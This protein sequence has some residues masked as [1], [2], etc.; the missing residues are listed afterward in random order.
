MRKTLP[1]SSI[2][3]LLLLATA[4]CAGTGSTAPSTAAD[5]PVPPPERPEASQAEPKPESVDLPPPTPQ[6]VDLEDLE[7]VA[8]PEAPEPGSVEATEE[9]ED[10]TEPEEPPVDHAAVLDDALEAFES[11]EHFWQEGNFEDAFAALDRAYELMASV[12]TN[13]DPYVAQ[14]K[15]DLRH[16]ISRR[17][18][19]IYASRQA[20]V[21]DVN[22]SIPQVI[23]EEV[24]REIQSFQGREREFFLESYRRSGLWRPMMLDELRK[25]GLPEQLSWL[26]LVESGFKTRALSRARALGLWQFIASTGY[27][28]GLE[29]NGWVDER[30]DPVEATRAAIAYLTDLHHLFG[31]WLTALAAY[32]CGEG[33]VLRQIKNQRVGYFDQFWDIYQRLPRETRRYVP[34]FLATLTILDDPARYG[35]DLPEPLPPVE[36]ESLEVSRPM[37]LAAL[38]RTLGLEAGTLAALNPALRWKATPEEP[39]ALR[40]PAGQARALQAGLQELPDWV[41]PAARTVTHRVRRGETLSQVASRYGASVGAIMEVNRLRSAHRIYPGQRLQIPTGGS[42]PRRA[43]SPGAEVTHRVRSGDSLW[44]LAQRYGTTVDR[45]RRDNGLS[46]NLLRP[47]QRLRI[48]G[49][50]TSSGGGGGGSYTVRRGDTLGIIAQRHGVSLRRLLSVNRL[51][52]RSTIYPGQRLQIP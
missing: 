37:E 15:E 1:I 46:G 8:Y 20:V 18:V 32:N 11:S 19:E 48:R 25:A 13:G 45:I 4:G 41:P 51:S 40:I 31:D 47:G 44:R 23:N 27:R 28:Y 42:A 2:L 49:S 33:T 9:S 14:Q 3:L 29:R 30:M 17:V 36:V 43:L 7:P 24:E 34:R 50:G 39:Y 5:S 12:P 22:G 38:D 10:A 6:V 21:G 35:F 52:A 16:V 26:P